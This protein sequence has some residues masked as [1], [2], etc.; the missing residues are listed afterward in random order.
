MFRLLLCRSQNCTC[1]SVGVGWLNVF[2]ATEASLH[3]A[4][5]VAVGRAWH[6]HITMVSVLPE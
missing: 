1:F 2:E 5:F 4:A 3:H 6:V